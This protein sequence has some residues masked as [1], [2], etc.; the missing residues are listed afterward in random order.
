MELIAFNQEFKEMYSV[1]VDVDFEVGDSEASNDFEVSENT[2]VYGL[3]VPGTEFGGVIEYHNGYS[4][5]ESKTLKG[6]TWRGL[7]TQWMIEP[8]FGTDYKVVSGELHTVM[9]EL[10][11]G[12]LGGFFIVPNVDTGIT[13][14]YQFEL[15][16]SVLKG[17]MDMLKTYGHRLKIYAKRTAAGEPISV[18]VEA[19][20][21][22]IVDG[23]YDEDTGLT[24]H[25]INNQMGI[26]HLI[27]WG[28][29]ELKNRQRVDLYV[30][31]DGSISETQYYTGFAERQGLY[32]NS[33]VE[34]LA[35]LKKEGIEKLKELANSKSLQI[36]EVTD[37]ELD[38]GDI[39]VGRKNDIGLI[40]EQPITR[41]ILRISE[42]VES[43]EYKVKGEG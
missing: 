21:I 32:E 42:G 19:V 22:A 8:D 1:D 26:N 16:V 41:K 31:A 29:G 37:V 12:V 6:W 2:L 43:I 4:G 7:L 27:C 28:K 23:T 15:H 38:I 30:G 24:L 9:R 25:F 39:V 35:D 5:T 33:G 18:F 13:V 40:V 36:D 10:L 20:P 11:S 14:N 34:S 17:L 3:Y